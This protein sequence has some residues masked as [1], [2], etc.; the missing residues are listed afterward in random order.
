MQPYEKDLN[1][2][3]TLVEVLKNFLSKEYIESKFLA[4]MH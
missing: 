2:D 4:K 1:L 3:F